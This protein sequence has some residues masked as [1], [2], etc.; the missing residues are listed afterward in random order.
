MTTSESL[1]RALRASA[2]ALG[3][4]AV[5]GVGAD[6]WD[7]FTR[8]DLADLPI[9]KRPLAFGIDSP[10]L[11]AAVFAVLILLVVH[12]TSAW[13]RRASLALLLATAAAAVEVLFGF[14]FWLVKFTVSE[15]RYRE[16]GVT[17]RSIGIGDLIYQVPQLTLAIVTV[18][19]GVAL[20]RG[21][22]GLAPRREAPSSLP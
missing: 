1:P 16:F 4:V 8:R 21:L 22:R 18:V 10:P 2:L 19:L 11:Y 13:R 6:V 9:W 5:A 17:D 3:V 7:T 15:E 20:L 14:G 12:V